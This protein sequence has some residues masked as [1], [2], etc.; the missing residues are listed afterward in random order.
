MKPAIFL[1]F[2][3]ASINSFASQVLVAV[4]ANFAPPM[5]IIAA[6]FEKA[7]G[8]RVVAS[9]GSTGA[10]FAQIKSGAP[11]EVFLSADSETPAR[12]D[13]EGDAVAGSRFTYAIGKLV[14][15]SR[16]PGA[17]DEAGA[18]LRRNEFNR[19]ALAN[20]K[21]APYGAAAVEALKSLGMY[22]AV[23]PKFVTATNITQSL[24]FVKSGN[25]ELG[26]I[27]LSQVWENGRFTEGSGWI[28]PQSLY[29]TI[30]QDAVLLKRGRD[31]PAAVALLNYLRSERARAVIRNFG[32]DL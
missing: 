12:L 6:D 10:L 19:L 27:A 20:P 21:L 14:L 5:K 23:K 7:T 30:H 13:N 29:S 32:Y 9:Y 16:Q 17:V 28:V 25:A 24:Q 3:L 22:E 31:N 11:F 1:F 4:A 2:L 8:H 18:V 15:W 26:F